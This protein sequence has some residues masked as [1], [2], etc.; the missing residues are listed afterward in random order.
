MQRFA[1]LALPLF[2]AM[3]VACG[4]GAD[5]STLSSNLDEV[6]NLTVAEL[7][8]RARAASAATTPRADSATIYLLDTAAPLT[9]GT[10]AVR[11][12]TLGGLDDFPLPGAGARG[13][14]NLRTAEPGFSLSLKK[15]PEQLTVGSY[16]CS[17][18][19]GLV[20]A[21][22]ATGET[23]SS[24]A[25]ATAPALD[26][27]LTITALEQ[28]PFSAATVVAGQRSI[29]VGTLEA[30]VRDGSGGIHS[31]RVA[32]VDYATSSP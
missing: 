5:S 21:T 31:L 19:G 10:D 3:V 15:L 14:V 1:S 16:A 22:A 30:S 25:T 9:L 17:A 6:G 29:S 24:A 7:E 26:C 12:E 13:F 20:T 27:S 18:F 2:T 4:E 32:V 8:A 23:Y 11:F 28:E